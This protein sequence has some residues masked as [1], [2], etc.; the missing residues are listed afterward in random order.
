MSAVSGARAKTRERRK[1]GS[2]K[3]KIEKRENRLKRVFRRV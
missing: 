2:G 3:I 1:Q